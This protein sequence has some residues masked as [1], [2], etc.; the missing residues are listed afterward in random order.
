MAPKREMRLRPPLERK[1]ATA[2]P[3]RDL[4]LDQEEGK[5]QFFKDTA[6][7]RPEEGSLDSQRKISHALQ[8]HGCGSVGASWKFGGK[9]E[10]EPLSV[11]FHQCNERRKPRR[12]AVEEETASNLKCLV[13]ELMAH[14]V[15]EEC[16]RTSVSK[17]LC[18]G[19]GGVHHLGAQAI[20]CSRLGTLHPLLVD[21][22]NLLCLEGR[23][24]YKADRLAASI[25]HHY[26]QYG[27][28]GS[29]FGYGGR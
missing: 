14:I 7:A 13:H 22:M 1:R 24:A 27:R 26:P 25:L 29:C 28:Y 3:R 10:K 8:L 19:V 16:N 18:G 21:Y 4:H 6:E 17:D 9:E 11:K 2:K 5:I 23:Q 20:G 12:K 15:G